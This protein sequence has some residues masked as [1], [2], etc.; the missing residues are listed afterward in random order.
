M[1]DETVARRGQ[2]KPYGNSSRRCLLLK[3][4]VE[5]IWDGFSQFLLL[6]KINYKALMR[7]NCRIRR[8]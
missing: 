2:G 4:A 5:S 1:E 8:K 3:V 6:K 7:I